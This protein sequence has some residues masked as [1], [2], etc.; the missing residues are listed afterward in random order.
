M[1][2]RYGAKKWMVVE[3]CHMQVGI[4]TKF[5]GMVYDLRAIACCSKGKEGCHCTHLQNVEKH[6]GF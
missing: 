1:N 4:S 3:W 2:R 5:K 6:P